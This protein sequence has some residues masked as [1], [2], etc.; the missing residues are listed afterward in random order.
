MGIQALFWVQQEESNP[1]AF[2]TP[3]LRSE[4]SPTAP[5]LGQ[6]PGASHGLRRPSM[7]SNRVA[8]NC[9]ASGSATCFVM[10]WVVSR[11]TFL[12]ADVSR[13]I[14][15]DSSAAVSASCIFQ[16]VLQDAACL[17]ERCA[18]VDRVTRF[19]EGARRLAVPSR[20]FRQ[21]GAGSEP[22]RPRGALVRGQADAFSIHL[23]DRR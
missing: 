23:A 17:P 9:V 10:P 11:K 20:C 8:E 4:L 13:V 16:E 21:K 15:C 12:S 2:A 14:R 5:W 3:V 7:S 19:R 22:T 18:M 1:R 6:S